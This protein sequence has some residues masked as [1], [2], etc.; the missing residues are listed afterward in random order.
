M[1]RILMLALLGLLTS[2]CAPYEGYYRTQY[3]SAGPSIQP[4]Y[5]RI[6]RYHVAPQPRY[7]YNTQPRYHHGQPPRY[8]QPA[9]PPQFRPYPP[10]GVNPRWHGNYRQDQRFIG[11]RHRHDHRLGQPRYDERLHYDRR[12]ERAPRYHERGGQRWQR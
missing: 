1:H 3:H 12:G 7:Y 10:P 6:D 4:G 5:Y 9:P 2:A 11:D 8:Y